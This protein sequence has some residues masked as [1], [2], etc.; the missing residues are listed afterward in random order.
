M[1]WLLGFVVAIIVVVIAAI[2]IIPMVV[3]PNDFKGEIVDTVRSATGRELSIGEE[4]ELSVFPTLALRLG[5]VS[6]SNAAGFKPAHMAAI[7]ELD[8]KVGLLPLLSGNLSVDKWCCVGSH[9]I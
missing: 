4:M 2:V 9:S 5:D 8:L 3:D 7:K 1:K 6:L